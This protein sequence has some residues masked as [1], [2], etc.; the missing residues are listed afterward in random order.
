[1]SK[2]ADL[3]EIVDAVQDLTRVWILVSGRFESRA[4]AVRRLSELGIAPTRLA[5]LLGMPVNQV[6]AALTKA[7][8]RKGRTKE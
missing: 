5:A 7:K 3:K 8:T 2:N 6:H 4:D 1:M